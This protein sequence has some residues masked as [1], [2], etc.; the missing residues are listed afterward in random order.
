MTHLMDTL[1]N[2]FNN[3]K[4]VEFPE[5]SKDKPEITVKK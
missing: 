3:S 4:Y 2:K 5:N 1:K